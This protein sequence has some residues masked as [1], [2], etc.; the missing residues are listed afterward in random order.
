MSCVNCK[1][2]SSDECRRF[3]PTVFSVG[4][5]I[6]DDGDICDDG[7]K[8]EF[9]KIKYPHSTWCGEFVEKERHGM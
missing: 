1:F 4:Y 7:E 2:L 6:C 9:P 3:P 5:N 8:T